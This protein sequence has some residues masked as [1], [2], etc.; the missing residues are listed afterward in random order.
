MSGAPREPLQRHI[1]LKLR[2]DTDTW[3]GL[4]Q[5]TKA[6]DVTVIDTPVELHALELPKGWQ[7]RVQRFSAQEPTD[8]ATAE[9]ERNS[10]VSMCFV[11]ARGRVPNPGRRRIAS[12]SGLRLAVK[13]AELDPP[14][15]VQQ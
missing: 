5:P 1:R 11:E 9:V 2:N 14:I 13:N 4:H 12:V 10:P 7:R 6:A 15:G 8:S 3:M